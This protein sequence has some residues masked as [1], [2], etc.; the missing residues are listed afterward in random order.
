LTLLHPPY[1]RFLNRQTRNQDSLTELTILPRH[2]RSFATLPLL[3]REAI[4]GVRGLDRAFSWPGLT[5][6]N[7]SARQAAP[8]KSG[9]KPPHSKLQIH[10]VPSIKEL[11]TKQK[12]PQ[13]SLLEAVFFVFSFNSRSCYCLLR[14]ER[15][16]NVTKPSP[17]RAIVPGSGMGCHGL[18]GA[19][20]T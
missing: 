1:L 9:V 18:A 2:S 16:A 11:S 17:S 19:P 15:D 20:R 10:V 8:Q 5:G 13:T 6:R 4:F 3:D 14:I 7:N 12:R